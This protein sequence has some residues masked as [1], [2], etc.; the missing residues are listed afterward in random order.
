MCYRI[1]R[2]PL[3]WQS[4]ALYCGAHGAGLARFDSDADEPLKT[5]FKMMAKFL[6]QKK[7][8]KCVDKEKDCAR[9]AAIGK[10]Q[11]NPDSMI[12]NCRKSC[13]MCKSSK[14]LVT[15]VAGNSKILTP[16]KRNGKT[17]L[18]VDIPRKAEKTSK[19]G[20][21]QVRKTPCG[22]V[23]LEPNGNCNQK[24]QFICGYN[25]KV[26]S[27]NGAYFLRAINTTMTYSEAVVKCNE[28]N[29]PVASIMNA[30][31]QV[32]MAKLVKSLKRD[33]WISAKYDVVS[34]SFKWA[35][36]YYVDYANWQ[37]GVPRDEKGWRNHHCASVNHWN[38]QWNTHPCKSKLPAVCGPPGKPLKFTP[39]YSVN[40][41]HS[42][43]TL[44][45][46]LRRR[47]QQ[48]DVCI[49]PRVIECSAKT[50]DGKNWISNNKQKFSTIKCSQDEIRCESGRELD[51]STFRV[52][53]LCPQELDICKELKKFKAAP[54][55][56]GQK[57]YPAPNHFVCRCPPGSMYSES[58]KKCVKFCGECDA[59]GDPHIRTLS[60]L[61]YDFMGVC[62]YK[63]NGVCNKKS[64]A[65]KPNYDIYTT[66]VPCSNEWRKDGTCLSAVE[67]H[68]RNIPV[69]LPCGSKAKKSLVFKVK[70]RDSAY[71]LNGEKVTH[72]IVDKEGVYKAVVRPHFF[73]LVVY[74]LDLR[75][76]LN[77][78][79]LRV[80][81]PDRFK[82]QMCGICGDCGTEQF[83]LKNGTKVSVPHKHHLYSEQAMKP[84][85]LNWME[86]TKEFKNQKCGVT[87]KKDSCSSEQKKN[88]KGADLCGIF[89]Q[90]TGPIKE[91]FDVAKLDPYKFYVDCIYDLCEMKDPNKAVCGVVAAFAQQCLAKG[92]P[93]DWRKPDFCPMKCPK[94]MVYH[95][96]A[97]G[98]KTCDKL[99]D[100]EGSRDEEP[101]EG[102][103]C[104]NGLYRLGN[105]CVTPCMCPK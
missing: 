101:A 59:W 66:N 67:V 89:K 1:V 105:K 71:Q 56:G 91:C 51:C 74:A 82:G 18:Q 43:H 69:T 26:Q 86:N 87:M 60:G 39:Y 98:Q 61:K 68:L 21:Y 38:G 27:D 30:E 3:D 100:P 4:A 20:C 14:Q 79:H 73:S 65:D 44:K 53:F 10:C 46:K 85:V 12:P 96:D 24:L 32:I 9:K 94:D 25:N 90:K 55:D 17:P 37:E 63:F 97:S 83:T 102:C 49:N 40:G 35:S 31:Q 54:C 95:L 103:V 6:F 33:A 81:V 22:M 104:K 64:F 11:N 93:V 77:G 92:V 58:S 84:V 8:E 16:G 62:R 2:D 72:Q 28:M 42:I 75:I 15:W 29:R 5:F 47:N 70:V 34:Q 76:L 19:K 50:K 41:L 13:G 99:S 36:N 23:V 52:R 7:K 88:V 57:C 78:I 48:D 80:R 45:E